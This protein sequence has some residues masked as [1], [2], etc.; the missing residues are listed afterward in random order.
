M[1][2]FIIFLVFVIVLSIIVL[3]LILV[4]LGRLKNPVDQFAQNSAPGRVQ[5]GGGAQT[6]NYIPQSG[7]FAGPS[8]ASLQRQ[9]TLKQVAACFS[10]ST[11]EVEARYAVTENE[12]KKNLLKISGAAEWTLNGYELKQVPMTG[13]LGS[14]GF[15]L[16]V[17]QMNPACELSDAQL[18]AELHD[19]G[20]FSRLVDTDGFT[21]TNQGASRISGLEYRWKLYELNTQLD[22]R[23]AKKDNSFSAIYHAFYGKRLI[24]FQ[25][26]GTTKVFANE[27]DFLRQT[28]AW[29]TGVRYLPMVPEARI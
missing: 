26:H 10:G 3:P 5:G 1:K 15:T 8:S 20:E 13:S 2:K 9:E 23:S 12:E 29:L 25:F 16:D 14:Q 19:S 11:H 22:L 7:T 6:I 27:R 17:F 24:S 28:Q 18:L 21:L 4:G